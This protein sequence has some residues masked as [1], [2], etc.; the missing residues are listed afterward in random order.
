MLI[1][2]AYRS[3]PLILREKHLAFIAILF[4][5]FCNLSQ[6]QAQDDSKHHPPGSEA[7]FPSN[8]G[9]DGSAPQADATTATA[10]TRASVDARHPK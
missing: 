3:T 5:I 1:S 9:G 7:R 2:M 8:V 10:A 4:I 6:P